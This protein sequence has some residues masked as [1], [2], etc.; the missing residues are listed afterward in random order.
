MGL[1][2]HTGLSHVLKVVDCEPETQMISPRLLRTRIP[3]QDRKCM[4]WGLCPAPDSCCAAADTDIYIQDLVFRCIHT[5]WSHRQ[6]EL[7]LRRYHVQEGTAV[8][9]FKPTQFRDLNQ[10]YIL[11]AK[12]LHAVHRRAE[13]DCVEHRHSRAEHTAQ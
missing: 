7:I 11:V 5:I 12:M 2:M 8:T 13:Q 1:S 4:H 10:T 9:Q 3:K 6:Q